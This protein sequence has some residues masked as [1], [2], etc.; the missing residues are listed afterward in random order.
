MATEDLKIHNELTGSLG[1][2][3]A[4]VKIHVVDTNFPPNITEALIQQMQT[5]IIA[6][7]AEYDMIENQARIKF[8]E[9]KT[10]FDKLET[11]FAAYC[12]QIYG[13]YGKQNQVVADF[14]LKPYQKP[15]GRTPKKEDVK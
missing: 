7:R 9:Y 11:A 2:F 4:G 15:K 6:K 5:E 13:F 8:D 1:K 12:F 14:G 10:Q 3:A